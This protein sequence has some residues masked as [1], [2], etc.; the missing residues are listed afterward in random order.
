MS[1]RRGLGFIVRSVRSV[2]SCGHAAIANTAHAKHE[3]EECNGQTGSRQDSCGVGGRNQRRSCGPRVAALRCI[4]G[5][6]GCERYS[7]RRNSVVDAT[8]SRW[9]ALLGVRG[10]RSGA[11]ELSGTQQA[12]T[13][14]TASCEAAGIFSAGGTSHGWDVG[15]CRSAAGLGVTGS[16]VAQQSRAWQLD[17]IPWPYVL[18]LAVVWFW[19]AMASHGAVWWCRTPSF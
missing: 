11:G 5:H 8:D 6:G 3:P 18:R 1:P 10:T 9:L 16:Q 19:L 14:G 12:G 17:G 13:A 4:G 2:R 15:G 7:Q